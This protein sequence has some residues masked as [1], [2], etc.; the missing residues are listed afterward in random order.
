MKPSR[1]KLSKNL[2]IQQKHS[3]S[4]YFLGARDRDSRASP[5]SSIASFCLCTPSPPSCGGQH[6]PALPPH[7]LERFR[8]FP[9]VSERFRTPPTPAR[10][11]CAVARESLSDVL[12][13]PASHRPR[14]ARPRPP[15]RLARMCGCQGGRLQWRFKICGAC[16]VPVLALARGTPHWNGEGSSPGSAGPGTVCAA[17]A[18]PEPR[19]PGLARL[20]PPSFPPPRDTCC[21]SRPASSAAAGPG[22]LRRG[23]AR[24]AVSGRRRGALAGP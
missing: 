24:L 16:A 19:S 8:T 5:C 14:Q 6:S 1:F 4:R 13:P 17:S 7:E 18:P 2:S 22:A 23:S 21:C 12:L 10:R 9:R 20:C 3:T 15:G 11:A